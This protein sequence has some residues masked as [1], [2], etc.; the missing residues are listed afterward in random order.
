[1]SKINRNK[2][3]IQASRENR[4]RGSWTCENWVTGEKVPRSE[5]SV[6]YI[7]DEF[8]ITTKHHAGT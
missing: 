3:P 1:M 4:K 7:N 5:F 6:R 2:H 8:V